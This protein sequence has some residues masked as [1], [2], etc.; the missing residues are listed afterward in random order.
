MYAYLHRDNFLLVGLSEDPDE[1]TQAEKQSWLHKSTKANSN[2]ISSL[3]DS[4][5][6]QTK[7]I[8]DNDKKTAKDFWISIIKT[9][10]TFKTQ[11]IQNRSNKSDALVFNEKKNRYEHVT[12]FLAIVGKLATYAEELPDK[13]NVSRL[14]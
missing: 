8:I 10:I 12:T 2:I 13:E 1:A 4:A 14:I 7:I 5:L 9:Y 6:A 11:A 3:G